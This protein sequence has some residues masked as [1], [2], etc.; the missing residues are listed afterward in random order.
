[1]LGAVDFDISLL[2]PLVVVD[3]NFDGDQGKILR[4]QSK[5]VDQI[6]GAV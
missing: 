1:V 3:A 2:Q 6:R 4:Y 5:F